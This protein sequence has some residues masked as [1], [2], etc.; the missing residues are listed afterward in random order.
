VPVASA[1]IKPTAVKDSMKT[2]F[3]GTPLQTLRTQSLV[4]SG[5]LWGEKLSMKKSSKNLSER[6][7]LE[8]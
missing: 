7:R 8:I 6:R 4:R 2:V 3:I 5:F 1:A